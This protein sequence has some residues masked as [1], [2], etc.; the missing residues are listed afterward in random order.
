M[1]FDWLVVMS[2]ESGFAPIL[3]FPIPVATT[4]LR[5]KAAVAVFEMVDVVFD[6][7]PA[8]LHFGPLHGYAPGVGKAVLLAK[9]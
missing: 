2:I 8:V 7:M 1:R 3:R 9:G 5:I 4:H 6:E